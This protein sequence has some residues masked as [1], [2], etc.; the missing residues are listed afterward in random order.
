[1]G[2][3]AQMQDDDIALVQDENVRGEERIDLWMEDGWVGGW[4]IQDRWMNMNE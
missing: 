4:N 1:M 3:D 2:V